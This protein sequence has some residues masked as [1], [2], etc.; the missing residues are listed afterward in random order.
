MPSIPYAE[1]DHVERTPQHQRIHEKTRYDPEGKTG[2]KKSP[3]RIQTP[4]SPFG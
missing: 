1:N 4:V 2:G 3:E